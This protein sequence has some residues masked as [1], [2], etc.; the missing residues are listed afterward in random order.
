MDMKDLVIVQMGSAIAS[1]SAMM[2]VL[3]YLRVL[4]T[5]IYVQTKVMQKT[6]RTSGAETLAPA[7]FIVMGM[8]VVPGIETVVGRLTHPELFSVVTYFMATIAGS[9]IAVYGGVFG[10][11]AGDIMA[12]SIMN[13]GSAES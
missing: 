7:M 1:V 4:P 2:A 3:T 5:V 8:E 13:L 6:M 10:A 12:A 9:V 11:N